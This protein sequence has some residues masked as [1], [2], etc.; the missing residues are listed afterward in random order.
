MLAIKAPSL[1]MESSWEWQAAIAATAT[2]TVCP[3]ADSAVSGDYTAYIAYINEVCGQNDNLV[4]VYYLHCN[5]K[6]LC[7][8]PYGA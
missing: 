4:K 8:N 5:D 1:K 6:Q 3:V 2:A 7:R